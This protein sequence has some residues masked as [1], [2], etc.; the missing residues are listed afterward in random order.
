M[1]DQT[2]LHFGNSLQVVD[3]YCAKEHLV[4]AAQCLH[5]EGTPPNATVAKN[6][7]ASPLSRPRRKIAD[8]LLNV[9]YD[10]PLAAKDLASEA[11]NFMRYHRRMW[12]MQ[13]REPGWVTGN[14]MVKS[15]MK[16]Y[17]GRF[18]SPGMRR[19]RP[20][21]GVRFSVRTTVLCAL[22]SVGSRSEICPQIET[23]PGCKSI[24]NSFGRHRRFAV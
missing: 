10:Y 19:S 15:G 1:W 9:T 13:L 21:T 11:D 17:Q 18:Y 20:R 24:R 7:R 22:T 14:G 23:I 6:P 4:A 8:Q 3:W 5:G 2:A 16:Q 12:C